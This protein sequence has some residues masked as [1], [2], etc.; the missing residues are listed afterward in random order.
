MDLNTVFY[1]HNSSKDVRDSIQ[2]FT[3]TILVKMYGP[4]HSI[5][6]IQS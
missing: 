2:Y 4:Q 1:K 5:L 3:G 6:Q